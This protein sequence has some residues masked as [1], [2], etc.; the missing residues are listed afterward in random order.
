MAFCVINEAV[1]GRG[2][3]WHGRLLSIP[4]R[5]P[6]RN[7][8]SGDRDSRWDFWHAL[9]YT[10]LN[11]TWENRTMA[12]M[13]PY[14]DWRCRTRAPWVRTMVPYPP[15][16]PAVIPMMKRKSKTHRRHFPRQ[17]PHRRVH[18]GAARGAF[19][20]FTGEES[21][22]LSTLNWTPNRSR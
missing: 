13:V 1:L 19:G 2:E 11:N 10:N 7:S 6:W 4:S 15:P 9:I 18:V 21:E 5:T 20:C 17:A 8:S 22:V 16:R 12:F 3:T 14:L